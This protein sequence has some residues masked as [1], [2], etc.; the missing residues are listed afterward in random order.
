MNTAQIDCILNAVPTTEDTFLA[1]LPK[2]ALSDYVREVQDRLV[3]KETSSFVVNTDA[4]NR[5]GEHWLAINIDGETGR[6]EWFDSYGFPPDFYGD[7]FVRFIDTIVGKQAVW[8]N[9]F[10]LQSLT[11][12]VCG[13]YAIAYVFLRS[14][15]M[16]PNNIVD[17]FSARNPLE[18]DRTVVDILR[19]LANSHT[20]SAR[21]NLHRTRYGNQRSLPGRR[22]MHMR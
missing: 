15:G 22:F 1:C 6:V 5:P 14:L 21:C 13:E 3:K 17:M 18:N 10:M 9:K 4:G 7:E 16:T 12:N 11:S 20:L 19:K 8:V 2:D